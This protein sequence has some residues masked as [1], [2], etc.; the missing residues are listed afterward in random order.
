[1]CRDCAEGIS[2]SSVLY[3]HV[4][5]SGEIMQKLLQLVWSL[6]EDPIDVRH[7]SIYSGTPLPCEI[8]TRPLINHYTVHG[9][10]YTAIE[11]YESTCTPDMRTPPLI[12]M[13]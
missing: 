13:L 9:P 6:W 3:H 4:L 7:E 5:P 8:G 10:S 2:P 1:M 11:V 12:R